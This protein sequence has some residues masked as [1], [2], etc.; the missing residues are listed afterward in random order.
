MKKKMEKLYQHVMAW[1]LIHIG[2]LVAN[3]KVGTR[4]RLGRVL[5]IHEATIDGIER[6][7]FIDLRS[8]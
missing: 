6:V 3:T 4:I 5:M 2:G 8:A 1:L 7:R